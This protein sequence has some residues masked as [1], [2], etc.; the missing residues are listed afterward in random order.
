MPWNKFSN[1]KVEAIKESLKDYTKR[2]IDIA[3]IHGVSEW[4]V[5]N[6][7]VTTASVEQKKERYSVINRQAKQGNKNP[8]FGKTKLNHPTAIDGKTIVCGYFTVWEPPWWT[9]KCP[10]NNR[11]YEHQY[12]WCLYNNRTEVPKGYVIHHKDHD[13]LNNSIDNLECLTRSQHMTY[14]ATERATTRRNAVGNSVPEEQS[15]LN[16]EG[17]IV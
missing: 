3:K 13:K 17:D 6:L 2:F 4:F 16:E 5:S 15:F 14:H 12:I 8:M 1:E 7:W 9:G 10:K 11:V